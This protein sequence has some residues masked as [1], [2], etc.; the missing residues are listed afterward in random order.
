VGWIAALV[1][2]TVAGLFVSGC[3]G[4]SAVT[5]S[6]AT[7]AAAPTF[8]PGGGSYTS[9]Q[10]VKITSATTGAVLYCTTDGT[11]PTTTSPQCASPTTVQ[12]SEYLQAIA[13]APGYSASPVS[14]A[15]YT[16][17]LTPVSTPTFSPAGGDYTSPQTVT[18][19]DATTGA[20]IYYCVTTGCKPTASSTQY[21][22]PIT[23]SSSQTVTAVAVASEYSNS[24]IASA[25]YAISAYPTATPT[26]YPSGGTYQGTISVTLSDATSGA[27]IYY[28]TDGTTPTAQSAVYSNPISVTST[29]AI[30]AIAVAS[31]YTTSAIAVEGYVIETPASM[32]TFSVAPGTYTG[33]QTVTLS[34]ATPNATIYYTTNG[35]PATTSS[36]IYTGQITV[37][38]TETINAIAIAT[39]YL[40]SA[41]AS[42]AYTITPPAAAP[43]FS[44]GTGTYSAIQQ[45]T[46][47]DTTPNATI[48]YTTN[49][50]PATTSSTVYSGQITVS[51]SET[52]NAVA[53]ASG[54]SV[55]SDAYA[56]YTVNLSQTLQPVLSEPT[57][58]YGPNLAIT[59]TDPTANAVIYYTLNG[60]PVSTN[61]TVYQGPITFPN[62]GSYTL[63]VVAIAPG[64]SLSPDALAVYT[65]SPPAAT[66]TFNVTSGAYT[67]PQSVKI[68]DT[69]PDAVIYYTTDGSTPTIGSNVYNGAIT[70]S[71]T[72]EV[73]SAIA[74]VASGAYSPSS[75]ASVE[76]RVFTGA[77]TGKV[78]SGTTPI[79]GAAVQLY[80]AG[81]TGY[82]SA[83][84]AA[85]TYSA[86]NTTA[87]DGSFTLYYECLAAPQ[88]Q[89][90][91][92]ATG[93]STG[94][95]AN[96]YIKLISVLGSCASLPATAT[97]NE[98]T[99]IASVYALS[100]FASINSGGGINVGVPTTG[101]SCN[102]T[103]VPAWQS[104]G[105]ETCNYNGL[106]S[107]FNAVNNMVNVTGA[108]D[109]YGVV[110]GAARSIT[111]AYANGNTV[112]GTFYPQVAYLNSSSVP[113]A[114]INAL[115]D[116]LASCVESSGSTCSGS[117]N[118]LGGASTNGSAPG[119]SVVSPQDTL[120]A[121]LNIAQNPGNNGINLT[122]LL[123]LIPATNPPYATTLST[124]A[125]PT[126]LTLALSY[127]GAGL[128]L[129]PTFDGETTVGT[130]SYS[131][132]GP[133][134]SQ[135]LAIDASGNIWV[136]AY[137][138][139]IYLDN[140]S[141]M[142]AGFS[143]QGSPLTPATTVT[144][145][146]AT[147][148][149]FNPDLSVDSP[150]P[151]AI[152]IDQAGNIWI[153][154]AS[155]GGDIYKIGNTGSNLTLQTSIVT[156]RDVYNLAIDNSG[157]VW[158]GSTAPIEY[159]SDG[160]QVVFTRSSGQYWPYLL[161]YMLFDA[162]YKL[163]TVD[164]Q[165]PL[166]AYRPDVDELS[167]A[168]G[169]EL[170]AAFATSGRAINSFIT[171]VAD[172]TG[173]VYGCADSNKAFDIFSSANSGSWVNST[174]VPVVATG[175]A[176]GDQLV[177]DGQGH[178]F[179]VSDDYNY[180]AID[181]LTT[182]GEVIS[183]TAA[184]YTGT[185]STEQ[186]TL[187][188]DG[189]NYVYA[190]GILAAMD[191]S[192]NLWVLNTDTVG[193]SGGSGSNV[194]LEYVGIGAPVV[195][196]TSVALT[197]GMLGV[198]P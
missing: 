100:A 115:A 44:T 173:Y 126:D 137:G 88:D 68:S 192:G 56:I 8:S 89:M 138:S 63:D 112:D 80:S 168:N 23:V 41:D 3:G 193:S 166:A 131:E 177:L 95:G 74:A 46:I 99:T 148:G 33:T 184:G 84:T 51:S 62:D 35:N 18:I 98:V 129:P 114:R 65:I 20:N 21:T 134:L 109:A 86:S 64:F 26:L 174:N 135:A 195:T 39:N 97:V 32:P 107:A 189:N 140:L 157:N 52:I 19:S 57:G 85:T 172:G 165:D 36:T 90:Y 28:T 93:G 24:D 5:S 91:L 38:Q 71:S 22:A 67:T 164:Y 83:P 146:T 43:T 194:L 50:T 1:V 145:T 92:V 12:S 66:P 169:T 105:K 16:I 47:S 149:G 11:T 159:Q 78:L 119:G 175:R 76:V 59:I 53:I 101:A 75:A 27:T 181:E 121:A 151:Q 6:E 161:R 60:T 49:G 180:S 123:D 125:A 179:A 132:V 25:T 171:L 185:S 155:F 9:V 144:G 102:A 187:N 136:T 133:T 70:V 178:L 34:D 42:A 82:G 108:T 162:N 58:V 113:Q 45:V 156:G 40:S 13:V 29:A 191:G 106:V 69:T 120:Q 122:G 196:P 188:F 167:T 61:S 110:A 4:N 130:Q 17:G 186:P 160:T 7:Q 124:S 183:P 72:D 142:L 170:F 190:N 143:S 54:Y 158:G 150:Q 152:A 77:I 73:I 55:S 153:G 31:G 118:L 127:T 182:Q 81:T 163:W 14:A 116:M 15:G 2:G 111:P 104:T 139:D 103:N 154:L 37:S 176:C 94:S 117:A 96:Q 198:R 128:G 87:S 48:Y 79:A 10:S 141:M 147:Y 30:Q 197:S